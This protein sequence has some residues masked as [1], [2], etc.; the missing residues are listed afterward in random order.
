VPTQSWRGKSAV[1]RIYCPLTFN[2]YSNSIKAVKRQRNLGLGKC[3]KI[4]WFMFLFSHYNLNEW[5]H[6]YFSLSRFIFIKWLLMVI[7][8]FENP[9]SIPSFLATQIVYSLKKITPFLF[10]FPKRCSLSFYILLLLTTVCYYYMLVPTKYHWN[11]YFQKKMPSKYVVKNTRSVT[12]FV[13]QTFFHWIL[14]NKKYQIYT[15]ES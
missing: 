15:L 5:I 1:I 12:H 6:S 2:G 11:I 8:A 14:S 4:K 9:P 10:T 3:L 13:W 7:C